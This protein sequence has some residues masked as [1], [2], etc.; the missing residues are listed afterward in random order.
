MF[1]RKKENPFERIYAAQ[2]S[3]YASK[4]KPQSID[5]FLALPFWQQE[6]CIVSTGIFRELCEEV[7]RLRKAKS[8]DE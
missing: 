4:A 1:K 2:Q 5:E 3:L 8:R 6:G 7:D